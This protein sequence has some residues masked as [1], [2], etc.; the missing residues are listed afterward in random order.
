MIGASRVSVVRPF[1]VLQVPAA[2][3]AATAGR[4]SVP[5]TKQALPL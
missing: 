3:A 4:Y 5:D 2:R 1:S